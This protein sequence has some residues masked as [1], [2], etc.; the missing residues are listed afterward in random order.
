MKSNKEIIKRLK[1]ELRY[2]NDDSVKVYGR[3]FIV[4]WLA[5]FI[6]DIEE[7]K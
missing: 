7:K 5:R 2:L 1:L 4:M 6:Q 3:K